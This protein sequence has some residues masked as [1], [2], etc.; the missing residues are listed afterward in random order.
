VVLS[1]LGREAN[2]NDLIARRKYTK[3]IQ[4]L[5]SE[6]RQGRRDPRLRLQLADVLVMAGRERE[7]VP[8]LRS[9]ADQ[10]ALEGFAAKAISVL[11]KVQRLDPRPDVERKLAALI[12][13]KR[14][15]G[16][17][18]MITTASSLP[19][20]DIEEIGIEP[21]QEPT[22]VEPV[23][24]APPPSTPPPPREPTVVPLT[25]PA[26]KPLGAGGSDVDWDALGDELLHVIHEV[27]SEPPGAPPA[28]PE[29][30]ADSPLFSAFS[31]EELAAVIGGLELKTFESG[32][33]IITEGEPGSSLFVL[34]SGI[35]K[36]FVRDESGSSRFVREMD[37]GSFLGEISILSGKPRT[38]TVTAKT[39]CELLELDRQRLDGI[40]ASQP[41]VLEVLKRFYAERIENAPGG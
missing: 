5:T 1:W 16:T 11:K 8:V 30:I 13:E 7:A 21:P 26:A 9:L 34:T 39:P 10:F 3:A 29:E 2:V 35:A 17:D 20:F 22:R 19:A 14:E 41:R 25:P 4:L 28:P 12:K 33:I 40:T 31:K 32:D 18:S 36:A 24:D 38:A 23:P 6:F 37:E 27:L 15:T